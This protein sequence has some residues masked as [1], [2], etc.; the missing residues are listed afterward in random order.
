MPNIPGNQLDSMI[1]D[2]ILE[3]RSQIITEYDFLR[4]KLDELAMDTFKQSEN[5]LLQKQYKSNE[6]QIDNLLNTLSKTTNE[7]TIKTILDRVDKIN[8]EQN[9]LQNRLE[10]LEKEKTKEVGLQPAKLLAK[11][12]IQMDINSFKKLPILSQKNILSEVIKEIIWDGENAEVHFWAEDL[13]EVKS[14]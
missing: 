14:A 1:V 2:E 12:L 6:M 9:T 3:L 11:N 5:Q 4:E 13:P 10:E 8:E 7:M